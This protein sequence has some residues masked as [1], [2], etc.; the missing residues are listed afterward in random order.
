MGGLVPP[1]WNEFS[2]T[3]AEPQQERRNFVAMMMFDHAS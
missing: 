3:V 2:P 1:S